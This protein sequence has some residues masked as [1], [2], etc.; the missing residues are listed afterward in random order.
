MRLNDVNMLLDNL[1]PTMGLPNRLMAMLEVV[2]TVVLL[3]Y[4]VKVHLL[5]LELAYSLLD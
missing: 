3:L 5:L 2:I 1:K 4:P